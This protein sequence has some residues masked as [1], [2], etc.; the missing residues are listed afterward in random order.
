[1]RHNPWVVLQTI[2]RDHFQSVIDEPVFREKIDSL[3]K[4]MR[5]TNNSAGLISKKASK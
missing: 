2:S 3:M 4:S 1:M 5:D